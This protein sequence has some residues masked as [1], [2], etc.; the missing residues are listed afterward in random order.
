M[1]HAAL[2]RSLF[3]VCLFSAFAAAGAGVDSFEK[4]LELAGDLAPGDRFRVENLLGSVTV[5]GGGPAGRVTISAKVVAEGET[6]DQAQSLAESIALT[7]QPGDGAFRVVWQG[8]G[9]DAAGTGIGSRSFDAAGDPL[10]DDVTVN[11]YG[12]DDQQFPT[13]SVLPDGRSVAIWD[14]RGQDGG[15]FGVFGVS[16][17][18]FTDG[19]ETG[20]TTAWSL[21]VP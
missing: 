9:L 13:V 10:G 14:S 12:T 18:I 21:S 1:P 16:G 11:V 5:E 15:L 20:D 19:F 7:H 17:T 3:F 2:R 4:T 6:P 8:P